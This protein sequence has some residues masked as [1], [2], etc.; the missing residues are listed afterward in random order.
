MNT[1]TLGR[2]GIAVSA[3]GMGC[4]GIGGPFTRH[5]EPVGWGEVDDEE[6][7]RAIHRALDLG[8]TFFDT[9]DVYGCGHSERIVARALGERRDAVIIATKFGHTFDE[10][11]KDITGSDG[12]PEYVRQCCEASLQRLGTDYIDLYQFH[13]GDY[14]EDA[15]EGTRAVLEQLVAEGKIR[16]YGWSTD[17]PDRARLFADGEHCAAIQHTLNLF[18][19]NDEMLDLCQE[20]DLASINRGPLARGLLTGKFTHQSTAPSNDVRHDWNF[21]DGPIAERI[22]LLHQLRGVLTQDG[23]TLAQAALGWILARSPITIPIPG[24]KTVAQVEDNMATLDRG[25]LTVEQMTA[26]DELVGRGA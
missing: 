16:A 5:G 25:P 20:N 9:A 22:D 24:C 21:Q 17:D 18:D 7:V 12:R 19:R 2:S 14:D 11:T 1:R 15:A 23:R 8:I 4:W 26:V 3:I 10:A 6:S 13:V